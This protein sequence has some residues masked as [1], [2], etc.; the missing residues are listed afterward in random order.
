MFLLCCAVLHWAGALTYND[1]GIVPMKVTEGMP[2][3]AVRYQR[4]G[5]YSYGDTKTLA[6]SLPAN[7]KRYWG[8]GNQ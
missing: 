3:E 2:I 7:V 8:M 5:G 4:V 1:L 6:K